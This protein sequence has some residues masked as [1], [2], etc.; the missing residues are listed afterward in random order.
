MAGVVD[1]AVHHRGRSGNP[2]PVGGGDDLGPGSGGELALGEDPADLVVEDLRCGSGHGPE[3][4]VANAAQEV[5][6][7]QARAGSAVG[8]L[9]GGE[10]V[11]VHVGD[12]AL[13]R[14]DKVDVSRG[15][16]VRVDAALHADLGGAEAPG[17]L[18][19][20]AHLVEGKRVGIRVGPSLGEGAEAAAD[21]A[22]VGEV[23]VAVDDVR[24]L[25]TDGVTAQVVGEPGQRS[26]EVAV[27]GHQREG[28]VVREAARIG[29]GGAERRA[30]LADQGGRCGD[31]RHGASH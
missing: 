18:G 10:R 9:H 8:D 30:A 23:D 24:D 11:D 22:H 26:E 4:G 6:H 19:A 7:R 27:S 21:V 5:G 14:G 29:L 15:R 12:A 1:V 25:L 3:A 2:E 13:D 31:R 20:V 17:L 28:V 16:E